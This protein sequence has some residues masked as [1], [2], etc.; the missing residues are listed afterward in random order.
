MIVSD[1]F[2]CVF[3]EKLEDIGIFNVWGGISGI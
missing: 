3:E 2:F 1:Y